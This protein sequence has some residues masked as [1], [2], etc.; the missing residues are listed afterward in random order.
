MDI[1]KKIR[2]KRDEAFKKAALALERAIE[3]IPD[4]LSDEDFKEAGRYYV[5]VFQNGR[6]ACY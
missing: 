2:R 3:K 6:R 5:E 1:Y 4:E